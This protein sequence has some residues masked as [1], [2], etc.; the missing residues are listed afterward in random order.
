M[1]ILYTVSTGTN[2]NH[3]KKQSVDTVI[4]FL[5]LT[6]FIVKGE[7]E[8]ECYNRIC[9]YLTSLYFDF[10]GEINV[11]VTNGISFV[12]TKWVDYE[13]YCRAIYV[14]PIHMVKGEF[15]CL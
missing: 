2:E 13:Y 5:P 8:M 3:K 6:T 14:R 4:P 15:Y 11:T 1:E 10:D 9:A 12:L 7:N